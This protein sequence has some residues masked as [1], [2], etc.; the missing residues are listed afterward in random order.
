MSPYVS[1]PIR[2]ISRK[3]PLNQKPEIV[4][5]YQFPNPTIPL[6]PFHPVK[7]VICTDLALC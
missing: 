2:Y 5:S 1:Y 4:C 7:S 3:Q 6:F